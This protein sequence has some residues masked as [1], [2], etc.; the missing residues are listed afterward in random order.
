[1]ETEEDQSRLRS[2]EAVMNGKEVGMRTQVAGRRNWNWKLDRL[3]Q[4]SSRALR[5][6]GAGGHSRDKPRSGRRADM[7]YASI[8]RPRTISAAE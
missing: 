8:P 1:M 7:N 4:G 2:E 3:R 6:E 5:P